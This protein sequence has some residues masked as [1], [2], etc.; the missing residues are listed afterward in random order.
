MLLHYLLIEQRIADMTDSAPN[1]DS[2]TNLFATVGFITCFLAVTVGSA[3]GLAKL[4]N[5]FDDEVHRRLREYIRQQIRS[6][7]TLR[8]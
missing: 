8:S 5:K 2:I 7:R 4:V 1:G 6:H 3:A